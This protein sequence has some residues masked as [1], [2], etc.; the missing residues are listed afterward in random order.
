MDMTPGSF[1]KRQKRC[2]ENDEALM[3]DEPFAKLRRFDSFFSDTNAF[4]LFKRQ[5]SLFSQ[6]AGAH[7]Q[8]LKKNDTR[9]LIPD[10]DVGEEAQEPPQ[11]ML[12]R[13]KHSLA[14]GMNNALFGLTI[15]CAVLGVVTNL[16]GANEPHQE[17]KPTIY[18][19]QI[20]K[21]F[22]SAMH[23]CEVYG[24][25][26]EAFWFSLC[27]LVETMKFS[28]LGL[29]RVSFIMFCLSL[30]LFVVWLEP[31]RS[32]TQFIFERQTSSKPH[33]HS[34]S[35]KNGKKRNHSNSASSQIS[36]KNSSLSA[37][38]AH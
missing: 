14:P 36:D 24:Q 1:L 29:P 26:G 21:N 16:S 27:N 4:E 12:Q 13:N 28:V 7:H 22:S 2:D 25:C 37:K 8:V 3:Q 19:G 38:S 15:V 30:I 9:L 31:V 10:H 11:V 33:K 34:S 6:A 32:L 5:D 23:N 35:Q 17:I 20:Q 18:S